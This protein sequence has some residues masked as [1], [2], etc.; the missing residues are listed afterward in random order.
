MH[1]LRR[2]HARIAGDLIH[3]TGAHL[4]RGA[5]DSGASTLTRLGDHLPGA[6]SELVLDPVDPFLGRKLDR[7]ILRADLGENGEV[8]GEVGDQLELALTRDINR[9][10]GDLDVRQAELRES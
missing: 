9:P 8:A 3:E 4:A 6:G 2:F 5:E 1:G 10:V 7:A